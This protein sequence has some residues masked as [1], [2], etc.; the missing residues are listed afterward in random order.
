MLIHNAHLYARY[1]TDKQTESTILDQLR[2]CREHAQARGWPIVAEYKDEGISGAA[3]GNRPA[4]QKMLATLTSGDVLI[5]MDTTRLSRSQDLAPLITR[6]RHR[7][8]RV[9]GVLDNYDSENQM[10]RMQAG[11]SGIMS[12]EFR[13]SIAAR[14]HSA[15]DMRARESRPTG[16]KCYGFDNAGQVVEEEAA[17][18]REVFTRAADGDTLRGIAS[19]LNVRG[20]PAPGAAWSRKV[21][22]SDGR[23]M[24]SAIHSML[25]NERYI[26]RVIWNRSQWLR[27]PDTGKRQRIERPASEWIVHEGTA[28]IDAQTWESIRSKADPRKHHGGGRGGAP[29]Y[30]LSGLL[31]CGIC[32]RKLVVNGK[33]GSHYQCGTNKYGGAAACTNSK[34]GRRDVAEEIILAPLHE[35]L[36][37]QEAVDLAVDLIQQWSRTERTQAVQ[38]TEVQEIDSRIARLEA[39]IAAGNLERAD[40]AESLETLRER[41]RACLGS[42]WRKGSSRPGVAATEAL[43]AYRAA[44]ER[45]REVLRGSNLDKAREALSELIGEVV[46]EPEDGYL[47]ASFQLQA[48]PLLRA[49]SIRWNGSGGPLLTQRIA[50]RRK[51]A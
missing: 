48:A 47:V 36:L 4:V 40:V 28:L 31:V 34:M 8:V 16:G 20:V 26:G 23:W 46:C 2:R 30:L 37:S 50:L 42:A 19:D 27:D 7:G 11:L 12:E 22:R 21:R 43:A 38:P 3:L 5:V 33:G 35:Q 41:R 1:S 18:V 17:I 51:A 32:D 45:F 49:A 25:S 10:A 13:A 6:L 15:L 9:V 44:A 39:Q 24:V 14:V 29:S